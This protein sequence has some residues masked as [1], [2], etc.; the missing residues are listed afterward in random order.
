MAKQTTK[1]TTEEAPASSPELAAGQRFEL[2]E[3]ESHTPP[4]VYDESDFG[5][6]FEDFTSE[7]VAVPFIGILQ[8]GSPQVEEDNPKY[9]KGAKPGMLFNT[10]SGELFDG[11][12]VGITLIPVHRVRNYI[13]W[14]PKDEGGG[15]V[16]VYEPDDPVVVQ[17]LKTQRQYGKLKINDGNDLVETF[18]VFALLVKDSGDYERVVVSFSSSQ[19]ATYKRWMTMAQSLSIPL[20]NGRRGIPPMFSHLYRLRTQ[21]HQKKEYTW[22]KYTV[23]W[24]GETAEQARL[25]PNDELYQAAKAFRNLVIGGQAKVNFEAGASRG[26]DPAEDLGGPANDMDM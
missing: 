5:A 2:V 3:T 18:S 21:F 26:D 7:D 24:N 22:Y 25:A 13:E 1:P 8:K 20:G 4:V 15:L 11:K 16:A 10:V 17:L 6:G 23:G 19:I 14:I 12:E 9:L